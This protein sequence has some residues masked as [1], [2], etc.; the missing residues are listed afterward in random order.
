MSNVPDLM[1]ILSKG[2]HTSPTEGACVMELV[3]YLAGEEWSD[4]PAC[5]HPVLA[6]MA[7]RVNDRLP[8]SERHVLVPLIGRL[9]GTAAPA[10]EHEAHVLSVR[11]AAW[12]ARQVLDRVRP[13]DRAAA[14]AA[15][16][17]AEGWCDG[18]VTA[19]ACARAA[20]ASYA[21]VR[22]AAYAAYTAAHGATTDAANAAHVAANAATAGDLA[23]LL[24]GL[25][26]EY[27]RLTGRTQPREVTTTDL[28]RLAALTT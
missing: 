19:T 27:D 23:G 8:D 15:I 6:M 25:L 20:A 11:L 13:E 4:S 5:T 22:A 10:D 2:A 12:C 18:S 9:F 24:A 17:A 1:P 21:V 14:E 7:R 16:V 28:T 26:D 3:S